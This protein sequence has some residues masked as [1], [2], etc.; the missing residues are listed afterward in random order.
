MRDSSDRGEGISRAGA[1]ATEAFERS[2]PTVEG[3]AAAD[4]EAE[5]RGAAFL[6]IA[7]GVA[8]SIARGN[9]DLRGILQRFWRFLR[10]NSMGAY[11]VGVRNL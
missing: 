5:T 9:Y 8:S 1:A 4:D 2:A 11:R 10:L 3:D 6:S 7:M